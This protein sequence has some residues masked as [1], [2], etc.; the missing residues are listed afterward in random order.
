[1]SGSLFTI[2]WDQTGSHYNTSNH[3]AGL[4][5]YSNGSLLYNQPTLTPVN[6]TLFNSTEAAATLAAQPRYE[7]ILANPNAPWGLPN[8]SA[9]YVF[10]SNGDTSPYEAWRM[11]DGLMW[12]D[13]IPDNR[14]TN[15]QSTTP[16]DTI[17]INLPRPRTFN[18]VSL[19]MYVDIGSAPLFDGGVIACPEAIKISTRN[20]SVLAERNP[21]SSCVPNALNTILFEAPSTDPTNATTPSTGTNV[22]TDYLSIQVVNQLYYAVAIS[23]IQIWVP[24][25]PGPRYEAEDGLLGT[26]IGSYEGRPS[27]LNDTI[28]DGGVLLG[29]TGWAEIADVR[30]SN[31]QAGPTNLTVI[32]SGTG[33]LNVTMN[34][35]TNTTVTFNGTANK[36]IEVEFLKGGNVVTMFQ[37]SGM[38]FI[39][40]IVVG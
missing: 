22:T 39:D 15:N 18:S 13:R 19:A 3:T 31:G 29:E 23:E 25:N 9:D 6:I 32:G 8:I 7:N 40:A 35:L 10:A 34:F 14:W 12:Y 21:W 17:E 27:G 24:A 30:T 28:Q 37:V 33:T 38:P 2:L 26:F 4:S 20:G 16:F 36:T 5:I 1:M 11:I